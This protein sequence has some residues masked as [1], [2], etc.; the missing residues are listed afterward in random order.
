MPDMRTCD[1][2]DCDEQIPTGR[3]MC[4]AHWFA[5][6]GKLRR[7]INYTWKWRRKNGIAEYSANVHEAR[8]YLAD[9]QG[10]AR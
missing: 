9:G 1:A 7:A 6:P 10:A 2:P 4:R 5:L 3:L 8:S